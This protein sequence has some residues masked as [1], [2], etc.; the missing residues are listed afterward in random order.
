MPANPDDRI[1]D[2]PHAAKALNR[3]LPANARVPD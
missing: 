1:A 3:P 2:T